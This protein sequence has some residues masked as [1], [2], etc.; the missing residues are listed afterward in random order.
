MRPRLQSAATY[1]ARSLHPQDTKGRGLPLAAA[2][3]GPAGHL[4]ER[5]S[6]SPRL[7]GPRPALRLLRNTTL[8]TAQGAPNSPLDAHAAPHSPP[9]FTQLSIQLQAPLPCGRARP[10]AGTRLCSSA[11]AWQDAYL[12]HLRAGALKAWRPHSRR[13][14][15]TVG[16][17]QRTPGADPTALRPA[18]VSAPQTALQTGRK[19]DSGLYLVTKKTALPNCHLALPQVNMVKARSKQV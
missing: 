7:A 3:E 4:S 5:V 17:R 12:R 18:G 10:L 16:P 6:P 1:P 2:L 19:C 15:G 11:S 8:A 14:P 9:G 13:P